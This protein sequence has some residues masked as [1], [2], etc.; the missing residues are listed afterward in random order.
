MIDIQANSISQHKQTS[1]KSALL[2][3]RCLVKHS[4]DKSSDINTVLNLSYEKEKKVTTL[5]KYLFSNC[6]DVLLRIT[7]QRNYILF[8]I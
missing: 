3:E 6:N 8:A 5:D 1:T 2:S 4:R 7:K